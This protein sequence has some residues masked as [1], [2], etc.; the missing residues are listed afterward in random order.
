MANPNPVTMQ[1]MEVW[2]GTH[3]V[4]TGVSMPGLDAWVLARPDGDA[5]DGGDIHYLSSC[6][7]GNISR[8]LI[9]DV[10]GHGSSVAGIATQLRNLMRR[11][12]NFVDQRKLTAALNTAFAEVTQAG[13]FATALVA[14]Y[15]AP[16]GQLTITSAGHPSPLLYRSATREWTSLAAAAPAQPADRSRSVNNI[17]LGITASTY[18]RVRFALDKGD[19]ALIYTDA[20]SEARPDPAAKV[21]GEQGLLS[22]LNTLGSREPQDLTAALL[23][24]LGPA[25]IRDDLTML[26]IR[27]NDA[28]P[29]S[30]L[31]VALRGA[32]DT[33]RGMLQG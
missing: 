11:Y 17:P 30:G 23:D 7:A 14:T 9:A 29:R 24:A 13:G 1:C 32:T 33:I 18:D 2:G 21:L 31:T 22:L 5:T 6:A 12:V 25:A 10:S 19:M 3:A 16:R 15:F 8:I 26:I 4:N 27:P 20:L 28:A